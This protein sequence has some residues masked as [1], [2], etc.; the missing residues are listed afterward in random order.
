M[1][2][3]IFG[4]VSSPSCANFALRQTV[5]DNQGCNPE[6]SQ[7]VL[8]NFYVDDMLKSEDSVGAA[9]A[10]IAS[11]Q[12]LCSSGGFNLTNFVCSNTNVINSIPI[13]KRSGIVVK[14]FNK[15]EPIERALGVH[16]CLDADTLGFRIT[17][18]DSPLTRRGILSTISSIYD[19][20]GFAGPF[21]LKG[22]KILQAITSLKD[23][24]DSKVPDDLAD[25]WVAWR[26]HLPRLQ[27]ISVPR[28]YKPL[29]F[30]SVSQSSLH[31][32]SDA[33]EIGYGVA[34]YLRQVDVSGLVNVSLVLGKSRVTP[35]KP[36]TIPRL[37]LTAAVVAVKAGA[38]IKEELMIPYLQ[39]WYWTDSKISLG[40]IMNDTR[41]FRVFVANRAQKIRAY[42]GKH[43][44]NYV[45]TNENP[46]D[47]AS[48]G[49]TV[50]D[51][52]GVSH[53]L[54]G[55]AF[56]RKSEP[57]LAPTDFAGIIPDD[58]PEV[59]NSQVTQFSV[60]AA[61]IDESFCLISMLENRLSSWNKIVRVVATMKRFCV[62][63][64][65]REDLSNSFT[66]STADIKD[67]EILIIRLIQEKYLGAELV[68]YGSKRG[69]QRMANKKR[70]HEGCLWRLDPILDDN[71]ILR[72]GGRMRKSG[73]CDMIKHPII[74]PK[75]CILSRRIAEHH[76]YIVKHSGRT[77]TLNSIRQHGYWIV[78]ATTMV[79]S[80]IN[81]CVPC[82]ILRGKL[83]EQR[84]AD[85]PEERF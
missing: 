27:D 10:K 84:M 3:H 32:F 28:C 43:Q 15:V 64:R 24:W 35:M 46:A 19:P 66:L 31:T 51:D 76:H 8:S 80:I 83:G 29:N 6:A 81:F 50:D 38:M 74:L 18:Q 70:R 72:V 63:A 85:L 21:L 49:L 34:S 62:R 13:S 20:F 17:L 48:R 56:L 12:Q 23:G 45:A 73:I 75:G 41:R 53:W 39:E 7:A 30:D 33:S 79:R 36:V 68:T 52:R 37:E 1:C 60:Q 55:P 4:A 54:K 9:V 2:V 22:R 65:K 26:A 61:R 77:S 11:V 44:W 47:L 71:R 78:S 82:R 40:Y 58:D 42:S 14:E 59:R 25:A 57:F 5:I 69:P 16:W 67:A